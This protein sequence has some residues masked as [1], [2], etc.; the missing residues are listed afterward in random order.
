[1]LE[2]LKARGMDVSLYP[3]LG[4][5]EIYATF[6]M[7]DFHGRMTGFMR[8]NPSGSKDGKNDLK[9]AKYYCYLPNKAVGV[10][11]LESIDFSPT[12]YLVSGM[13]KAATLH[14]LG[15]TSLHVSNI[16]PKVLKAQLRLM[17]RPYIAIGDNDDEGRQF[18]RRHGGFTSPLDVDEMSDQDI[19]NMIK[20]KG[21]E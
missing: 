7:Y 5:D 8:Y 17:C 12:I 18:V 10:W 11:G 2:H 16:P 6:P 19:L 21:G 4:Y 3:Y 9:N 14:R 15:F 1:M 20:E 13:F